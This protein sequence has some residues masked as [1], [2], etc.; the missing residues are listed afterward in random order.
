MRERSFEKTE[1]ASSSGGAFSGFK[2]DL[3]EAKPMSLLQGSLAVA[4]VTLLGL[5]ISSAIASQIFFGGAS[6]VGLVMLIESSPHIKWVVIKG[7]IIIDIAIFVASIYALGS[8]GPT[9]A[10]G[11]VVAG[12]GYT[13]VVAPRYR[14]IEKRRK[15]NNI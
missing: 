11:L 4:G 12:I 15:V 10:G 2:L 5:T 6:L 1:T 7:N 14:A 9:I 13:G 3:P 8:L